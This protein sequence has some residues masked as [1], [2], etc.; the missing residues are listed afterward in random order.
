MKGRP[1]T[2]VRANWTTVESSGSLT[3]GVL[4][5]RSGGPRSGC[6]QYPCPSRK[7]PLRLK[8]KRVRVGADRVVVVAVT[9]QEW[10]RGEFI[11]NKLSRP[12]KELLFQVHIEFQLRQVVLVHAPVRPVEGLAARDRLIRFGAKRCG[13]RPTLVDRNVRLL[14]SGPLPRQLSAIAFGDR[15]PSVPEVW[16][17]RV[18]SAATAPRLRS[19]SSH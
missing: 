18:P 13:P 3:M 4:V 12:R 6:C 17:A 10:F 15:R 8:L 1:S 14:P 7:S 5:T 19:G 9:D 11:A 16:A 2:G